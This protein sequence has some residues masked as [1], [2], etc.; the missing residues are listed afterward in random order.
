MHNDWA[1]GGLAFKHGEARFANARANGG[2]IGAQ[3]GH[4]LWLALHNFNGAVSAA[5]NGGW[6]RV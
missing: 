4:A 1:N 2:H 3:L 6:K 5:R